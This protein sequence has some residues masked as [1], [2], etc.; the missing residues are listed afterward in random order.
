MP[1]NGPQLT[2]QNNEPYSKRLIDRPEDIKSK[3]KL[4]FSFLYFKQIPYFGFE[5]TDSSWF[6][7]FLQRLTDLSSK[8]NF[9]ID[10]AEK[11][12]YRY[13]PID[14]EAKNIPIKLSDLNWIPIQYRE[15]QTDFPLKQITI[16]TANGR[17]VGFLNEESNVFH[18]VLLD[19]LHNI[20][21]S[22]NYSYR[23]R[24]CEPLTSSFEELLAQMD[25]IRDK[26]K[27]CPSFSTGHNCVI[28]Q[29]PYNENVFCCSID[30]SFK[31]KLFQVLKENNLSMKDVIEMGIMAYLE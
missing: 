3:A 5:K 1:R 14:W 19:P 31:E 17:I 21:P 29:I 15:N 22:G 18:I 30:D 6:V 28:S 2:Q 25:H 9:G 10:P 4:S 26:T 20:Q 13:H 27:T 7:G 23:I 8:E 12:H 24:D 16:S 11:N